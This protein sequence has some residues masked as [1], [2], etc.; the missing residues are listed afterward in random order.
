MTALADQR[1]SKYRR[2]SV[3][4]LPATAGETFFKGALACFDTST[5]LVAKGQ[6]SATLL[7]IGKV[8]R[9]TTVPAGGGY[10]EVELPYEVSA[11]YFVNNGSVTAASHLLGLAYILDD[12]TVAESD[13]S[14]ARSVAGRI[15]EVHATKGVLVEL[16]TQRAR[17]NSGLDV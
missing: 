13:D 5:H 9:N 11:L 7:P 8:V 16:A 2:F 14:N 1:L 6:V 15:W 4:K 17:T 10:V 3:I 12:Q